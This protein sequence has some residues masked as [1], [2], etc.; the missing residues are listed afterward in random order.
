MEVRVD[1]RHIRKQFV[2]RKGIFDTA[3]FIGYDSERSDFR[4]CS[5]GC[6]DRY[7]IRF[8]SHLREGVDTLSY[9]GE[10]HRHIHEVRVRMLVHDPHDLR[11]VHRRAAAERDYAIRSECSHLFRSRFCAGKS[12]IGRNVKECRVRD[13]HF[14]KFVGYRLC[15][16]VAVKEVVRN[17][18]CSLFAHDV[19]KFVESNGQTALL[20]IYLF[21]G[22]EPK[23]I[24]SPLRDRFDVEQMLDSDIFA[25]GVSSP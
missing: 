15:V 19:F 18:E 24:F 4:T 21:G 25:D 1:Y 6:R 16:S 3:L 10:T 14:V 11:G 9:I 2:I 17:N 12:R 23:H 7:E 8:F 5:R 20:Y 22:S 13:S